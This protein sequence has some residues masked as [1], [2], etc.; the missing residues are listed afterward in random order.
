[1]AE[2]VLSE[3]GRR[4]STVAIVLHWLMAALII[5]QIWIGI[6]M[7][8][9]IND[10]E[11]QA[12]AY[13]AFQ[14]HKSL[15]LSLLV[16]AILRLLWRLFH[17]VPA[18]PAHMPPWQRLAA[19]LSHIA[20][21]LFM[22]FIPLTGWLYVSTGWNSEAG[23]AFQV[24]TVWFGMFEWPHIPGI[25]GASGLADIVIEM[26]EIM[27]FALIALLVFHVAAALKHHFADRDHVLWSMAPFIRNPSRKG[28]L[29]L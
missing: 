11:T 23:M 19:R 5:W 9:A 15:G 2:K 13:D 22:I 6:W 14:F 24:P 3:A 29:R 21:Y 12:A 26:H 4:Y 16:L 28:Q 20:L 1:M 7:T 25:E 18:L 8:G 17:R 27:A 10:P